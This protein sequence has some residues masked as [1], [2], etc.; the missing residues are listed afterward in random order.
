M[1]LPIDKTK[2]LAELQAQIIPTKRAALIMLNGSDKVSDVPVCKYRKDG[3]IES[4]VETTRDV[5]TGVL[6][7]TRSTAW[8][9]YKDEPGAPVDTITITETVG[10]TVT[11]KI[12][13]HYPD[14][15]QP[16]VL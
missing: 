10:K 2:T 7:S 4:Q 6:I 15:K 13:K 9:Y 5:E 14:G 8:T 1:V 16:E 12:I 11:K 3:Q